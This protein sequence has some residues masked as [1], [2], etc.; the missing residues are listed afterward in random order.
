[1]RRQKNGE[2]FKNPTGYWT[3]RGTFKIEL[4]PNMPKIKIP[5]GVTVLD[6][7]IT[8][9]KCT[10]AY[11]TGGIMFSVGEI[12]LQWPR[13]SMSLIRKNNGNILW[14]NLRPRK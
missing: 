11:T 2:R 4:F 14:K 9:K 13:D 7:V 10:V 3:R 1:M 12:I 6:E 8:I 5:A